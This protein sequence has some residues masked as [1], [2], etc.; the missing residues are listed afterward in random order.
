MGLL[1]IYLT[2]CIPIIFLSPN[3]EHIAGA[4]D[5]VIFWE[6]YGGTLGVDKTSEID[7]VFLCC[8]RQRITREQRLRMIISSLL[9]VITIE[10]VRTSVVYTMPDIVN[11][12]GIIRTVI[13]ASIGN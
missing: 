11:P 9:D 13:L 10:F 6:Q 5:A 4:K 12:E 1:Y 8:S 2:K 7:D 3:L